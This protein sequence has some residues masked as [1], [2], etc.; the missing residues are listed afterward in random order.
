MSISRRE[1]I[2]G[3]GAMAALGLVGMPRL[4]FASL[5]TDNR[6]I[7]V[8]LRGALDGLAAVPPYGDRDYKAQRR[9]LAF[10]EPGELDGALD[11]N[12]F[13]GLNPAMQPLM[14]LY[15]QK[16]LAVLHAVASPYRERSHFDAQNLLENGTLAAN[17]TSGWLNRALQALKADAG[18]G[19]AINQQIPLVL[20][21]AVDVGSWAAKSRDVDAASDYMTKIASLYQADPLL[22][23]AFREG[24]QAQQLAQQGLS[25][26]DQ[27]ADKNAKDPGALYAAAQAAALFLT[28]ENGPRVAVMEA[29]GWDTHSRQGTADGALFKRLGDLAR[30]L[31]AL[32]EALGPV[33]KK[34]V[35]VVVTEFGRTVAV[36]GTEGT[37]H[38]T[39]SAAFVMGGGV[40][41]GKVLGQWPGLASGNLYQNRDLMPTTDMRSIFKTVLYAHLNAP[42][43]ELEGSIFPGSST[44]GMIPGLLL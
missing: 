17:G 16:Q 36:N 28:K 31:A 7:L 39:G 32:P 30:G 40:H 2:K 24:M 44:A 22:S 34:T 9:S 14:A 12:G 11:L 6:F 1:F 18:A 5:P 38:G 4:S 13:F 26:D 27:T 10:A 41:G 3:A 33:W 25:Q 21:G 20:Q 29:G 23:T 8:I 43:A 15:Q 35:V 37:D 42:K 19:I